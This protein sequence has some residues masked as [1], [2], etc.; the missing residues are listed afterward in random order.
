MGGLQEGVAS[1][2]DLLQGD[3]AGDGGVLHQ[4]DD[5]VGHGGHNALDHLQQGNME[6][7]LALGHAQHLTGLLLALGHT[8]DAAPEDFGEVERVVDDKGH[9][10]GHKPPRLP[11]GPGT[12]VQDLAGN[13]E[14]N[15]ELEHEGGAPDD[16]DHG[17]GEPAQGGKAAHRAK[18]NDQAQGQGAHEGDKK[19]LQR[20]KKA[21]VQRSDD[22]KKHG[23]STLCI[24]LAQGRLQ[25]KSRGRKRPLPWDDMLVFRLITAPP[26]CRR[27]RTCRRSP[28]WC[29]RRTSQQRTC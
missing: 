4:G 20:L 6:E 11:A 27:C 23:H 9:G 1:P 12:G 7:D 13:V 3:D 15:D 2:D 26:A 16:P 21:L 8:L 25:S 17:A 14:D 29:R 19:Q 24:I 5:L 10:A 28:S 18:R 22:G